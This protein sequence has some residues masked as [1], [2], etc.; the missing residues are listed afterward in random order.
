MYV[1][2]RIA[3]TV[4]PY[5]DS[6][7]VC[8]ETAAAFLSLSNGG[9]YES[10]IQVYSN[11]EQSITGFDIKLIPDCFKSKQYEEK[12][13]ILCTTPEQTILDLLEHEDDV[14]I[15]TLLESLSNYYYKHNE[16]FSGLEAHMNQAQQ[17]AFEKWKQDA[18]DYYTED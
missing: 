14:D 3:N 16:T 9:M 13:G 7:I 6:L 1:F 18:I 10:P 15:Q 17:Q 11:T 8:L 2:E 5:K 4:Y 12:H